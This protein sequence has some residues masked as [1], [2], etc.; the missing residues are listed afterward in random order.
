MKAACIALLFLLPSIARAEEPQT[1]EEKC[2]STAASSSRGEAAYD[3]H[4]FD[5][6]NKCDLP[7]DAI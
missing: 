1:F 4:T 6:E 3:I 5:V 7:S 2:T